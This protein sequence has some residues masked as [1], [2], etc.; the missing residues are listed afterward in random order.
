MKRLLVL[1]ALMAGVLQLNA[2]E[3]REINYDESAV[4]AYILPDLLTCLDGQPVKSV[5]E[6][7]TVR[8][9]E[10]MHILATQEYGLTPQTA[11]EM[12]SKLMAE[13][14]HALG[15]IATS[16]QVMLTFSGQGKTVKALLLAYIPNQ[17][18]GKVPVVVGYNFQGNHSMSL[19]ENILYS[20]FFERLTDRNDPQLKRG[21]QMSRWP[22]EMIVKRGYALVTM[23]YQ[24]IYPDNPAGEPLSVISLFPPSKDN[25]TKW[26]AIGAWAW[27]SSRMADWVEQQ[28]WA[29]Q[30]RLVIMGH[31][32]QGKAAL[33]TGAQDTRFRVVI[34]N[35]SG[36]G[37]AALSKRQFGEDIA[38]IVNS[39]PHWFCP[40]FNQYADR[41]ESLSFDQHY[42]L[43]MIAPRHLY[44]ASAQEDRWADPKG[45]FLATVATAPVYRLYGLDGIV[46]S[47]MPA[48]HQ[49]LMQH[50]GYHIR[51][52]VHDV[53]DYDW[54]C[55]LDFCDKA[56]SIKQD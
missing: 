22:L 33:W 25:D 13:D 27:G 56:F 32:R 34:S 44:V 45:E 1:V 7:E 38:T 29:D 39:F 12:K 5:T 10:I 41:E 43:A 4:P 14:P 55:Y 23:D 52:G 6:W 40:A 21:I 9:P 8:R 35:D 15:G 36:C 46:G 54:Q 53:T 30:D 20:P 16:Q 24:D 3:K 17:R 48:I 51:A 37:G 31:S 19:D 49:P 50:T 2:Q 18:Q 26:Q 42:L 11:I 47:Q 28:P